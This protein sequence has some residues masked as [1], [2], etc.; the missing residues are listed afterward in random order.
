MDLH[1]Q[2]DNQLKETATTCSSVTS[3]SACQNNPPNGLAAMLEGNHSTRRYAA[4]GAYAAIKCGCWPPS[5]RMQG[6]VTIIKHIHI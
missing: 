1:V 5:A 3:S 6:S 2:V 4:L